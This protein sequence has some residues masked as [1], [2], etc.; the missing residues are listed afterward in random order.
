[1]KIKQITPVLVDRQ[2][3]VPHPDCLDLHSLDELVGIVRG[4]EESEAAA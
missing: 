2:R 1:M 3:A 4:A